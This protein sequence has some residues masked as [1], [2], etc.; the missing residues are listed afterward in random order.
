MIDK[1]FAQYLVGLGQVGIHEINGQMY[2]LQADGRFV[3]IMQPTPDGLVLRT[4]TGLVDYIKSMI[5][6]FG[7]PR[8]PE[9]ELDEAPEG[10]TP[11]L[12]RVA[13]PDLVSLHSPLQEDGQRFE[14]VVCTA[15]VPSIQYE[16]FLDLEYF[17]I[18]LQSR[19]LQTDDRDKILSVIGTI[20]EEST[21]ETKDDGVTQV[22]TAKTGIA[23]F[24]DVDVPNPVSL[25]PIRTFHEVKQPDSMFVF[26]MKKG[27]E[28]AIFEADGEAW[29]AIAM[30]S[31]KEYLEGEL[32]G[33]NVKVLA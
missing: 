7:K 32:Y 17:N 27:P 10:N 15:M 33:Y 9:G 6:G 23:R 12:I 28:A 30:R 3:H 24:G 16:R 21:Q 26:R 11:V 2:L 19:F 22:V 8:T 5:D 20:K 14:I 13:S 29:K 1:S 31:V 25:R 4:L 18:M